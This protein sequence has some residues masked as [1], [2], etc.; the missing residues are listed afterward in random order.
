MKELV[1]LEDL[2]KKN[3]QDA[4]IKIEDMTGT[5]DH[6]EIFI[7]SDSFKNKR[8]I[9]QHRMVMD[10]LKDELKTRIHAVKLNI[11]TKTN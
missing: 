8:L 6:L 2:L 11:Q 1:W 3:F 5:L 4:E 9:E 7:K 10:I